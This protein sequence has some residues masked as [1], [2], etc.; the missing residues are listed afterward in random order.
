MKQIIPS[1]SNTLVHRLAKTKK[2]HTKHWW[3]ISWKIGTIGM[4]VQRT[5]Y[6]KIIE[7]ELRFT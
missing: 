6:V 7:F 3:F 5:I 1:I 4:L 2:T